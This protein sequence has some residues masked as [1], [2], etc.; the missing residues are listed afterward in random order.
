MLRICNSLANLFPVWVLL[1][2]GLA[3][4]FPAWFTWFTGPMIV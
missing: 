2:S 1:C 4:Y 3:L